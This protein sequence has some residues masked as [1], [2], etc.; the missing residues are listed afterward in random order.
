MLIYLDTMIVQ[1][2]V[3]YEDFVFGEITGH[4]AECP[5][6]EPKLKRELW[7][8]RQLI[9][10]EQLGH[11]VYAC[12]PGLLEELHDG[13]PTDKQRKVYALLLEAWRASGWNDA[14]P[15]Q[16][17]EVARIENS[18]EMLDLRNSADR[19]YLAEAI[20][21]NASWFLS[22]DKEII[23]KCKGPNLPLR[24]ARPSECLDEISVGLFPK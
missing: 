13:K 3:D 24:V 22:N 18:L 17:S 6:N 10:L 11:W 12:T 23:A 1:Y 21:L 20:V 14:F 8:L 2:C 9:F 16:S 4:T 19:R 15:L 7:A 5:V